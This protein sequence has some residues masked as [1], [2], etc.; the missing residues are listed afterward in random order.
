MGDRHGGE[1]EGGE[2][3]EEGVG[4]VEEM[5]GLGVG[6]GGKGAWGVWGGR[7]SGLVGVWRIC[8]LCLLNCRRV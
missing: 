7:R 8:A 3:V 5:N 4:V 2:G 6:G 1:P